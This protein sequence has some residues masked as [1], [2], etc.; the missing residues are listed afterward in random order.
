[1]IDNKYY[2]EVRD[3]IS[4]DFESKGITQGEITVDVMPKE[5]RLTKGQK[6]LAQDMSW[7]WIVI[8]NDSVTAEHDD[9]D[10]RR[11]IG[12]KYAVAKDNNYTNDLG[13]HERPDSLITDFLVN[14][15]HNLLKTKDSKGPGN[16]NVVM[17]NNGSINEVVDVFVKKIID[18][19]KTNDTKE[20][21]MGHK[22]YDLVVYVKLAN[23]GYYS[24]STTDEISAAFFLENF[25]ICNDQYPDGQTLMRLVHSEMDGGDIKGIIP[26]AGE[27][28]AVDTTAVMSTA[29]KEYLQSMVSEAFRSRNKA[30]LI[31]AAVNRKIADIKAIHSL[32]ISDLNKTLSVFQKK[33]KSIMK[34]IA[35]LEIYAGISTELVQIGEGENASQDDKLHIRQMTLYMDEEIGDP[36]DGGFDFYNMSDFDKWV[37]EDDNYLKLVPEPKCIVLLKPRR[38][39]KVYTRDPWVDSIINVNNKVP[40]L[41]IRNGENLYR[42]CDDNMDFGPRLFPLSDDLTKLYEKYENARWDRD[43]EEVEDT[44]HG[45]SKNFMVIQ[46]IINRT[47]VYD[48]PSNVSLFDPESYKDH[49]LLVADEENRVSD[50]RPDYLEWLK[51]LNQIIDVG[52]RIYFDTSGVESYKKDYRDRLLAYYANDFAIP[53]PPQ[54]GIYHVIESKSPNAAHFKDKNT[55]IAYGIRYNPKDTVY[56]DYDGHKRKVPLTYLIDR[57]DHNIIN[58]EGIDIDELEYYINDRYSRKYYATNMWLLKGILADK[59]EELVVEDQFINFLANSLSSQLNLD[60]EQSSYCVDA[61][62]EAVDWWKTKVKMKRPINSDDKKAMEMVKI[63]VKSML[64]KKF[65]L[66]ISVGIDNRKKVLLYEY[67]NRRYFGTGFTKKQFVDAIKDMVWRTTKAGIKRDM[68]HSSNEKEIAYANDN[69]GCICYRLMGKDTEIKH[70]IY[71]D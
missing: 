7:Q 21:P 10:W 63:R 71:H 33:I 31:K 11:V 69:P 35:V 61:T 50:G 15:C 57:Y 23:E 65:K 66:K 40:Y 28:P 34:V 68:K 14:Q 56:T 24:Y 6:I 48:M 30:N 36:S 42:I 37:V 59:K 17:I 41:L 49:L 12:Y 2:L 62:Y 46:S 18:S 8:S 13:D 58:Y 3:T 39:N 25:A 32:M 45:Y 20:N 1:M 64:K 38:Y 26:A 53:P 51:Q 4:A 67:R 9:D 29:S 22:I 55:D 70:K 43:K 47:E 5:Y 60:K 52:D 19:K 44:I 54:S 27:E 16:S